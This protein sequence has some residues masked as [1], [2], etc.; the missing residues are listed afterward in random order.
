MFRLPAWASGTA[1]QVIPRF[2]RG[3]VL[4]RLHSLHTH[5]TVPRAHGRTRTM[6]D[7][8]TQTELAALLSPFTIG[9]QVGLLLYG[10]YLCMHF[11]YF[12]GSLY[13]RLSRP[14]KAT[15]WSVL[16]LITAHYAMVWMEIVLWQGTH[17]CDP[18]ITLL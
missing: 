15:L 11:H 2:R 14:V 8:I 6:C 18:D 1:Q 7:S 16:L 13:L 9:G 5:L 12:K 10:V 4:H 3:R 17:A